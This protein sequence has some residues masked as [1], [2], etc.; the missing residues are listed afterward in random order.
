[1]KTKSR[2]IIAASLVILTCVAVRARCMMDPSPPCQ[3]FWTAEVVFT[4]T[5]THVFYSAT[6][7]KGEGAEKWNYR[8]RIA[9]F[10]VD[11]IFRGR[12]GKHVDVIAS[13]T[14][15][16]PITFPDGTAGSKTRGESDCEYKFNQGERY[17]VYAQFRKTNDGT[18]WVGYNRTRPL[19]QASEDL[20]FIRD[21]KEAQA[22]G[23]V[24]GKAKRYEQ[25]LKKGGNS[26]LIA[27]VENARIVL[28]G[29][30]QKRETFTDAEGH[31]SVG[32]LR[33]GQYEVKAIFPDHLASYPAQKARV[34]ERGCAEINFTTQTDGRISGIVFDAQGQPLPKIR[35]DL[36][37]AD[38]EQSDPNPQVLWAFADENGHY[39]FRSVPAGRYHLGIRLNANRDADFPFPRAYYPGVSRPSEA[40]VFR[41]EE[42]QRIEKVDFVMPSPL[43]PRTI[44]GVVVGSDGHPMAGATVA[45]M[46]TNY[47]FTFAG[48]GNG[49]TDAAGRFSIKAFEGFSYWINAVVGLPQGQ[50][51][52]EPV[53]LPS[54]GDLRDVKLVITSP[55]GNCEKCRH[56]Y[57]P[58]RKS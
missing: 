5:A 7:Q 20:S 3:A 51:H 14:M 17:I 41:L 6:Y 43:E 47:P 11:Q 50:M 18:L 9:R 24:F 31:Y 58:K 13:E 21:L 4:G 16:T 25:D 32:G 44:E 23:R 15:T 8:D 29:A 40:K 19:A 54:N 26:S 28:E 38:Q 39:E 36:A 27:P 35:L 22:V 1:M 53:D 34:V 52:A 49:V 45:L 33:P 12:I 56:R 37:R 2:L 48:G 10:T 30:G 42:G 46:I 57:W 55:S